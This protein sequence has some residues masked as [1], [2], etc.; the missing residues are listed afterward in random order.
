MSETTSTAKAPGGA[1]KAKPKAPEMK[2]FFDALTANQ[3][4][5]WE[6]MESARKRGMRV[7]DTLADSL[8]RSQEDTAAL[9]RKLMSS[10]RDYRGNF[11]AAME[12]MA[13]SQSHVLDLFKAMLAEYAQSRESAKASAQEFYENSREIAAA[14]LEAT[15][16]WSAANPFTESLRKTMAGFEK[17]ADATREA[18]A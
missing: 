1:A 4:L 15:Q 17:V 2:R 14:S 5:M 3:K 8:A 18:L 16:S 10:P 12:A 6:A 7:N 9:M 13:E 11:T